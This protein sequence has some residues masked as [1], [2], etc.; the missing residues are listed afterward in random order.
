MKTGFRAL[1]IALIVALVS[2]GVGLLVREY[3]ARG[4]SAVDGEA[5]G[6]VPN[7]A[8]RIQDFHRVKVDKGRKVWEVSARE[9]RYHDDRGVV[10]VNE[11]VVSFFAKDGREISLRGEEGKVALSA[12]EL[13]SV[14]MTGDIV[15]R[16]GDYA[17]RTRSARYERLRGMI[18]APGPVEISGG[19]LEARSDR[20]EIDI[21]HHILRLRDD[22][23][24]TL[25]PEPD[26]GESD[27]GT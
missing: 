23:H 19:S 2:A 20:M 13:R 4:Q 11:P 18:V 26:A 9:A 24:V 6:I 25:R 1:V 22:V 21:D 8:Q 14:E 27:E 15:V 16:L 7:V 17:L 10:I 12:R 5:I 3:W